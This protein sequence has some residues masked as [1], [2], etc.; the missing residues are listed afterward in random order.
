MYPRKEINEQFVPTFVTLKS[1]KN[2][3]GVVVKLNGDRVTLNTDLYNPNQRTSV[4]RKEVESM[5]PSPV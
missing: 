5:G 2:W 1:G 3:S 4:Q